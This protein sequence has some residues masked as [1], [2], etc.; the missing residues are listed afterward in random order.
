MKPWDL[1]NHI[2]D[3]KYNKSGFDV[4]W[5]VE[6]DDSEKKI[7][8]LFEPSTSAKDWIVNIAGFLPIFKFPIFYT[9]GWKLAFDS[10]KSLI[11]EELI[12]TIN[13]NK[14]YAVEICGHSYGG[15]MSIDAGIE[16]YKKTRIKADVITFGAPRC[17]FLF[18][19]KLIARLCLGNVIQYAHWSDC[20]T[21]CP[22]LIGYHNIK[23]KRLGKF[24]IKNLFDPDTFHMIYD[25]ESLYLKI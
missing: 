18:Y 2:W 4:D 15:A 9:M 12:R 21:Y 7:R 22:P 6:L 14:D 1:F 17:L 11:L 5:K 8:L 20:V 10:V 19:S 23:V 13:E 16:L 3:T 25:E 24:S